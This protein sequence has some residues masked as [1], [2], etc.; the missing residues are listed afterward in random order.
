MPRGSIR[1]HYFKRDVNHRSDAW[2]VQ[3]S[4]DEHI[5]IVCFVNIHKK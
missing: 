1:V 3:S 5:E 2:M 4:S